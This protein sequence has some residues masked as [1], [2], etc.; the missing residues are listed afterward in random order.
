MLAIEAKS[1]ETGVILPSMDTYNTD[2]TGARIAWARKR[3]KITASE[4]ARALGVRNVYLSQLENNHRKPSRQMLQGLATHLG[5]TVGF[6]LMETDDPE[7]A[8]GDAEIPPIYFSPEADEAAQLIDSV[9]DQ[10]ERLRMLAVLRT[11]AATFSQGGDGQVSERV[12]YLPNFAQRLIY[13][14]R[15]LQRSRKPAP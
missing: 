13:G 7:P 8:K 15:A 4:L 10:N 9:I 6:L 1:Y 14:E 3:K 11:L 2:S 12:I 5:T